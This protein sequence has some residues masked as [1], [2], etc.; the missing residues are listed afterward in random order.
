MSDDWTMAHT[1]FV[2]AIVVLVGVVHLIEP[3]PQFRY[4]CVRAGIILAG[5]AVGWLLLL[6]LGVPL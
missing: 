4:S 1:V 6:A 2:V 5:G 3:R